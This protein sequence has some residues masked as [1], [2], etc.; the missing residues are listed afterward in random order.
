MSTNGN[1]PPSLEAIASQLQ[2]ALAATKDRE[3]EARL[4]L[5]QVEGE[6]KKLEKM[7]E[8]AIGQPLQPKKKEVKAGQR[9]GASPE[10]VREF[11]A[12]AKKKLIEAVLSSEPAFP[13]V[14]NSFTYRSLRQAG[15]DHSDDLAR[16]ITREMRD[17]GELRMLGRIGRAQGQDSGPPPVAFALVNAQD[18]RERVLV[19]ADLSNGN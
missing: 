18:E 2:V 14:P 11:R 17:S 4:T 10:K 15:W 6:R 7:L 1:V 5:T 16:A 19:G 9:V 8:L 13:D 3:A 12:E